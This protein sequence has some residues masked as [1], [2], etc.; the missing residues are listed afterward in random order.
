[1]AESSNRYLALVK[2]TKRYIKKQQNKKTRAKTMTRL[3][4]V[5]RLQICREHYRCQRPFT[6]QANVLKLEA[7]DLQ[8]DKGRETTQTQL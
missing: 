7:N 6:K 1:M 5:L 4:K 3:R 8:E 2:L